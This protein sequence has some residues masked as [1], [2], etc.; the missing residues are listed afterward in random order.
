MRSI[1]RARSAGMRQT[2]VRTAGIELVTTNLAVVSSA[3]SIAGLSLFLP[4]A[5]FAKASEFHF[6]FRNLSERREPWK[7]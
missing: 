5:V 2:P 4:R 6:L 3:G 7:G 1:L